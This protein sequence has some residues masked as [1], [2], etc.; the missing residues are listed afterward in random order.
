[1]NTLASTFEVSRVQPACEPLPEVPYPQAIDHLLSGALRRKKKRL[2]QQISNLEGWLADD[3][4]T[5]QE[6]ETR[7]WLTQAQQELSVIQTR[8]ATATRSLEA[9]CRYH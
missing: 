5:D 6:S 1:M 3:L 8:E 2:Q 4:G 7:E 9:C